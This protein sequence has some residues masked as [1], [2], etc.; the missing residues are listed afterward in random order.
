MKCT[1][2]ERNVQE[3][4]KLSW[5]QSIVLIIFCTHTF[6]QI[7]LTDYRWMKWRKKKEEFSFKREEQKWWTG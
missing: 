1:K 7:G 6:I 3:R 4:E 2:A 5:I